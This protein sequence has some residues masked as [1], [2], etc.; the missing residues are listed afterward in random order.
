MLDGERSEEWLE[1]Q[2]LLLLD[3]M[4]AAEAVDARAVDRLARAKQFDERV[5]DPSQRNQFETIEGGAR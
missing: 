4:F 1:E 3:A 5:R 2:L